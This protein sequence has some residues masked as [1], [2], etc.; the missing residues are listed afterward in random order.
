MR[1][2]L[3]F[4]KTD[5]NCLERKDESQERNRFH[6]LFYKQVSEEVEDKTLL[7]IIMNPSELIFIPEHRTEGIAQS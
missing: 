3:L 4:R 5:P 2:V 1:L 6:R 7:Y